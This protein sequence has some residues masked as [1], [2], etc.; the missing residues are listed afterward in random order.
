[1]KKNVKLN[2]VECNV[3]CP[4]LQYKLPELSFKQF[5]TVWT[6]IKVHKK[7]KLATVAI[8]T[9]NEDHMLHRHL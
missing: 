4:L 7:T 5:F 2:N 6:T 8:G 9:F 3:L 1:M